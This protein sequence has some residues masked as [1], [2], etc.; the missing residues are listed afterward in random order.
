MV[1]PVYARAGYELLKKHGVNLESIEEEDL[2]HSI[3]PKEVERILK[4][5]KD[6]LCHRRHQ[7]WQ[8]RKP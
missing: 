7:C 6:H 4:F 8:V 5:F 1:L 2:D 3:S